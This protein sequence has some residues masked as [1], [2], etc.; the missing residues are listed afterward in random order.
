MRGNWG[1]L[2][3]IPATLQTEARNEGYRFA[4]TA[5][6]ISAFD[7]SSPC[8]TQSNKKYIRAAFLLHRGGGQRIPNVL[9]TWND[10]N[11]RSNRE[12]VKD[13]EPVIVFENGCGSG[14][15]RD[16]VLQGLTDSIVIDSQSETV[17][18][19]VVRDAI[20]KQRYARITRDRV[21]FL[22][23]V[24][25]AAEQTNSSEPLAAPEFL[26]DCSGVPVHKQILRKI[27]DRSPTGGLVIDRRSC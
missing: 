7:P 2:I 5:N 8:Q 3:P 10:S 26:S 16:V 11:C 18:G 14:E 21:G 15:P 1:D 17:I 12:I 27:P 24:S 19:P 13:F 23:S 9:I 22:W 20:G 4:A 6:S 25:D